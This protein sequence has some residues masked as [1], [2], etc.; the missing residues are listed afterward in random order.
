MQ[1]IRSICKNM[2]PIADDWAVAVTDPVN[3]FSRRKDFNN[4]DRTNFAMLP[5]VD[6]ACVFIWSFAL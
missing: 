4:E 5:R 2:D 3:A 6:A 1:L